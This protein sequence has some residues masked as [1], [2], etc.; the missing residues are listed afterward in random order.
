[1]TA[2][3]DYPRLLARD[4]AEGPG[5]ILFR[6]ASYSDDQMLLLLDR[7][8]TRA[9][10]LDT[11]HHGRRSKPNSTTSSS[12]RRVTPQHHFGVAMSLW[13]RGFFRSGSKFGSIPSQA[14][15]S[16]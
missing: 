15:E 12:D 10:D 6:G 3:L 1:M 14:G 9:S 2:D 11:D 4:F 5:L 16:Q 7:V 8:L 13:N